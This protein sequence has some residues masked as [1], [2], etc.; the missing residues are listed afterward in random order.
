MLILNKNIKYNFNP[1]GGLSVEELEQVINPNHHLKELT[2]HLQTS[3]PL[4]L[5]LVGRKGRG[6]T[7]HLKLLHKKY[8]ESQLFNL[9]KGTRFF[10][11]IINS[12]SPIILIDSIHHL[13]IRQR[14]KIY[15]L[16]KQIVFSTHHTKW[17]ETRLSHNQFFSCKIKGVSLNS[18][19][20]MIRNRV[21][22]AAIEVDKIDL[23]TKA[24][25]KLITEYG[26]DYRGILRKL[27]TNFADEN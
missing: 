12:E 16:P 7:T 9:N 14:L 2:T 25:E 26:D 27:Y 23:N 20:E 19:K 24:I 8:P 6:K 11:K 4:I 15:N 22:N 5:E 10:E 13:S 18:L 21:E 1:F 3:N 17:L